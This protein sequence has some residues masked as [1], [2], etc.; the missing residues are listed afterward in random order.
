MDSFWDVGLQYLSIAENVVTYTVP[1]MLQKFQKWTNVVLH[2]R[3]SQGMRGQFFYDFGP[4]PHVGSAST[5]GFYHKSQY[6]VTTVP[7]PQ[8]P[9]HWMV[10]R[11]RHLTQTQKYF[12]LIDQ[13]N[14]DDLR[15]R[16][17][18][19]TNNGYCRRVSRGGPHNVANCWRKY[20]F[21]RDVEDTYS[22]QASFYTSLVFL[23]KKIQMSK[24]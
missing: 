10:L 4:E 9:S 16:A 5:Q 3:K 12:G 2:E 11:Q 22:I 20:C 7:M 8:I 13:N 19:T 17:H 21:C 15:A 24:Y 1:L 18:N 14:S 6:T 23:I